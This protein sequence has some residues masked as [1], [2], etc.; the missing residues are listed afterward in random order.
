M[1]MEQSKWRQ[2]WNEE[3]SHHA[4]RTRFTPWLSVRQK[5]KVDSHTHLVPLTSPWETWWDPWEKS[6]MAF[7]QPIQMVF[8]RRPFWVETRVP[9]CSSSWLELG[10]YSIVNDLNFFPMEESPGTM[11]GQTWSNNEAELK[12]FAGECS[13]PRV[14]P[15]F[16]ST[17][18]YGETRE[19]RWFGPFKSSPHK[20]FF[21]CRS[22]IHSS[23]VSFK[24]KVKEN[25]RRYMKTILPC[26]SLLARRE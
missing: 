6:T 26:I 19:K 5:Q 12:R 11:T 1:R 7:S 25:I 22:P 24:G 20:D 2:T 10:M 15:G 17:D 16:A 21:V 4:P 3:W 8:F 23:F 9:L 14:S 18:T 13:F